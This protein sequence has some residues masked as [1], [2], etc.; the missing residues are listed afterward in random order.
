MCGERKTQVAD[1]VAH[2][3]PRGGKVLPPYVTAAHRTTVYAYCSPC[4]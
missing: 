4:D 1:I 2:R 3:Y